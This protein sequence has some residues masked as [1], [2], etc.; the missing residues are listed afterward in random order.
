[1]L[2]ARVELYMLA[3]LIL[4]LSL[5]GTTRAELWVANAACGFPAG[6]LSP[7]H[8]WN[9]PKQPEQKAQEYTE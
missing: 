9:D 5:S 3:G 4:V 7:G 8:S 6:L 2:H 1:M